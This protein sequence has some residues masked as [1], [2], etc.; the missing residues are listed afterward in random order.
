MSS[1]WPGDYHTPVAEM[2]TNHIL[3]LSTF[4]GPCV[5]GTTWSWEAFRRRW[6][7]ANHLRS[8]LSVM[9]KLSRKWK[10]TIT[11]RYKS[12]RWLRDNWKVGKLTMTSTWKSLGKGLARLTMRSHVH[13]RRSE[14]GRRSTCNGTE[15]PCLLVFRWTSWIIQRFTR[16]SS[17]QQSVVR[18]TVDRRQEHGED[19]ENDARPDRNSVQRRVDHC[20]SPSHREHHHG[21]SFCAHPPGFHWHDG[22][23]ENDGLHHCPHPSSPD[24]P[25][26]I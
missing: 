5:S 17:W 14:K 18:T 11:R 3:V 16:P 1:P 2:D 25:L 9:M 6:K 20:E 19:E 8:T 26:R 13:S 24:L 7:S 21:C 4:S 12:E 15:L 23:G 22:S 10:G